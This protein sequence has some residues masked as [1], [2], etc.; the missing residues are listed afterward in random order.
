MEDIRTARMA[1]M[2]SG[3][4]RLIV[5]LCAGVVALGAAACTPTSDTRSGIALPRDS[6]GNSSNNGSS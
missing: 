6:G 2:E 4:R 1:G 5:L 3:T